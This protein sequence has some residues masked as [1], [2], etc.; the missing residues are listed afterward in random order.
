MIVLDALSFFLGFIIGVLLATASYEHRL[1][2]EQ[3]KSRD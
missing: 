2:V 3:F 1:R